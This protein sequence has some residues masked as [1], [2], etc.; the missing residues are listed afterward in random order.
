VPSRRAH[1][2]AT[3]PQL[4]SNSGDDGRRRAFAGFEQ[5]LTGYWILMFILGVILIII[6]A[7]LSIPILYTIGIVLAVVGLVLWVL[8]AAGRG[9]GGRAHYY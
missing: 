8:G 5:R 3:G 9:V 6:G 4:T 2:D 7:L 1:L